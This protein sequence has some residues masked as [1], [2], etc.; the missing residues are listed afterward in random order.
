[1]EDLSGNMQILL[2][3]MKL[4]LPHVETR[5]LRYLRNA[6]F[7][8]YDYKFSSSE[9][10]DFFSQFKWYAYDELMTIDKINEKMPQ[11]FV[12]LVTYIKE[13]EDRR[14]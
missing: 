12:N 10:M 9:F 14:K 1:M 3:T 7:A 8:L 11:K 4:F 13:E 6:I 2:M 5:Y